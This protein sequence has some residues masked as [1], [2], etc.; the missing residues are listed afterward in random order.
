MNYVGGEISDT[1]YSVKLYYNIINEYLPQYDLTVTADDWAEDALLSFSL[2]AIHQNIHQAMQAEL[3]SFRE[4]YDRLLG[5]NLLGAVYFTG[6]A[7]Q[8]NGE[9]LIRIPLRFDGDEKALDSMKFTFADRFALNASGSSAYRLDY[10]R[11]EV[12]SGSVEELKELATLVPR[13][14]V[15]KL[16]GAALS[17][18][19]GL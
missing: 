12:I 7:I 2:E 17:D 1:L 5:Q 15:H 4:T 13:E 14:A 9:D 8:A 11:L 10:G 16:K 3:D 19:L 6:V 18:S